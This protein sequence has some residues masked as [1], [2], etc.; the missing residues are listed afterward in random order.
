MPIFLTSAV[1]VYIIDIERAWKYLE[2]YY[3]IS[4]ASLDKGP[5]HFLQK[6]IPKVDE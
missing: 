2:H 4:E 1:E 5:K 3:D 6:D